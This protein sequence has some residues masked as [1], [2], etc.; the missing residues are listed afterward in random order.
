MEKL[1][2][3]Q[4]FALQL[5]VNTYSKVT[6]IHRSSYFSKICLKKAR[7]CLPDYDHDSNVLFVRHVIVN[8]YPL[9]LT[10]TN[11]LINFVLLFLLNFENFYAY[12]E[13]GG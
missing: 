10:A 9:F 2:S 4:V 1:L 11:N 3:D 7:A 6:V 12:K 8:K 5:Q 13:G